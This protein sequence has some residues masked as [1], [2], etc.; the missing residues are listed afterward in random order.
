MSSGPRAS[1]SQPAD[2]TASTR[3]TRAP[4]S[5]AALAAP[6]VVPAGGAIVTFE[7]VV[8]GERRG[9]G[10]SLAALDYSA[11]EAM[12]EEML[13]RLAEEARRRFDVLAAACVHRL[14]RLEVGA[15]SVAVAVSAGHRG[16][17]FDACRWL[18]DALKRDAPIWKR[19]CWADGGESWS[20]PNAS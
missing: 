17:A 13:A 15:V 7:G 2:V 16:P 8:R 19:D 1:A 11:Y 6:L 4:I 18:I 10:V 5:A 9:D 20:P 14:G 3:L 12:A